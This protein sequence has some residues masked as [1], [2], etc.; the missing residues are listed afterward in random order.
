[1]FFWIA[2][3]FGFCCDFLFLDFEAVS[4]SGFLQAHLTSP[5]SFWN[6]VPRNQDRRGENIALTTNDGLK[7]GNSWSAS[8]KN[9][10]GLDEVSQHLITE[11]DTP[12]S[13]P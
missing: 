7:P 12:S 2:R 4:V 10:D 5:L 1:L 6:S 11:L 3:Q 13:A 8:S 9:Q